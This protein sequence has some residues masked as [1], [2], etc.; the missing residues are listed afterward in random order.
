MLLMTRKSQ[1]P[2]WKVGEETFGW[3]LRRL[4]KQQELTQGELGELAQASTRAVCS[5]E[6]DQREPP[7]HVL[8]LLAQAL[9]VS[10]DELM[11][12]STMTKAEKTSISR[13]WLRKF[14]Q[15]DSLTDRKQR[16]IMQVLDMALKSS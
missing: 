13:R 7:A 14:E 1:R 5:Y 8:P 2:I 16:A 3:R 10:L 12:L 11:G 6:R 9:E 15:I 4:R